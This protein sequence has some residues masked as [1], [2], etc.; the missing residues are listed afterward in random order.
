MRA[1]ECSV[2]LHPQRAAIDA[3]AISGTSL[4]ALGEQFHRSKTTIQKHVASH[5]AAAA[6]KTEATA[7]REIDAGDSIL[8]ELHTLG[9][10]ARRLQALAEKQKDY[11]TAMTA[12]RELTRLIEL[13]ARL[14]GELRD[15]EINITNVQIDTET[16]MRMAQMYVARRTHPAITTGEQPNAT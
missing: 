1:G 8:A 12:I 9:S 3:A 10:E 11:R 7:A 2:C 5:I 13:K 4:R 14:L 6:Q 15:R 16:A